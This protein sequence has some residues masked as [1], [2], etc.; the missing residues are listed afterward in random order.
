M[1]DILSSFQMLF[2]WDCLLALLLGT[3]GGM[4]IGILP[5]LGSN[6]GVAI[7]IPLTYGMRPAAA[8]IML[9]AVYASS[10]YGG[11]ITAI[12]CH[13]PGTASN[14]ATAIDGYELTK[15]GRG[16]EAVGIATIASMAGGIVGALALLF[17]APPLAA[18]SLK[19]SV[20][21]FFMLSIFG[22]VIIGSLSSESMI[23]GLFSGALGLFLGTFG[24]DMINGVPRYTFGLLALEDG[25]D[26]VPALI[27]LFSVSQ[28]LIMA[29][30]LKKG[31][32]SIIADTAS[33]KK[34]RMLPPWSE[35]KT[36]IP[37]IARSSVVGT[38]VGIIP[39][40]GAAISSWI[41]YS[42][43]KRLSKHP[44]EFG[45]G[46]LEAVA[47]S[48]AGNNAACGGAIVPL[49]TLGIP[50]SSVTA[51]LMGGLLIHGLIPG[52]E[53]FTTY[54]STTYAICFGFLIANILMAIVGFIT[55]RPLSRVATVPSAILCPI[56]IALSI[57]GTFAIRNSMF[58]VFILFIFGS[59]GYVLRTNGIDPAPMV[60]GMI[61]SPLAEN[62]WRRALILSK[63]N[64]I[65]YFFSRPISVVLL[66]LVLASLFAPLLMNRLKKKVVV[67]EDD[68]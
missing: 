17:I 5:G 28:A 2:Q 16:M 50:G 65:K 21:E 20:L 1:T 42:M 13:T 26:S 51:I 8:L 11:S 3:I 6:M 58:D 47:C 68:K 36:L 4:V 7:L 53:M 61:L 45:K 44:E 15:K 64:M 55:A 41:N 52:A 39:A 32:A 62:N 38:V 30:D 49:I 66:I 46:S 29:A 67:K 56:I 54:A 59:I 24:L 31:R 63:G 40:A 27:G 22:L 35:F 33:I 37:H 18:F 57:V 19:F 60:L 10:T 48:E 34:G 43:G 23:K 25:I 14:A 12:L 9:V